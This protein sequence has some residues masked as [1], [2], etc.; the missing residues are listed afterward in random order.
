MSALRRLLSALVDERAVLVEVEST[1]GSAPREAGT[2]M[3]VFADRTVATIGGGRLEFDA[4]AEARRLL[5]GGPAGEPLRRYALGPSLGQ[6]CGGVVFL[7]YTAVGQDDIPALRSRLAGRQVP[8]ALFGGGHVGAA[9]ARVLAALPFSLSWIDSRD[10]IFPLDVAQGD[11]DL[12]CEHSDPVHAAVPGLAPQSRV[13][14]MSFSHA[15]DLDVVAAC[16]QRQR[17]RGDLP[18]IGLIGSKTKWATFRS[19]L[20]ARGFTEAELQHVTCPIGVPGIHG[21]EPEVIAV[22]VAAQLLQT[23]EAA[24]GP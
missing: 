22:A 20:L 21:K 6:C 23:L 13:L 16:L 9:L 12:V 18:F 15:E 2:W 11:G 1:Q 7:R 17:S 14:I 19:R 8:V 3:A 4:I 5:D 24:R 10:E